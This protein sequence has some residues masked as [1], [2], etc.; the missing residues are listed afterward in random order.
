MQLKRQLEELQ[1]S[2]FIRPNVMP[3]GTPV[4]FVNKKDSSMRLCID[5]SGFDKVTMDNSVGARVLFVKKKD[6]SM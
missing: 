5:R 3:C 2:G 6:S 1:D 4:L